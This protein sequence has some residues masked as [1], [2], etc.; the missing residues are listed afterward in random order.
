MY[1]EEGTTRLPLAARRK[2]G[3][4]FLLFAALTG[5]TLAIADVLQ[6][7]HRR[8]NAETRDQLGLA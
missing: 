3:V 8:R 2:S 4:G 5:A 7:H 6:E 1:T